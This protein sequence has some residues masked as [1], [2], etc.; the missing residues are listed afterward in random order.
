MAGNK[1]EGNI[2]LFP[3]F[4]RSTCLRALNCPFSIT[5]GG[6]KRVRDGGKIRGNGAREREGTHKS[7]SDYLNYSW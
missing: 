1:L 5:T 4:S 3:Y 2:L 6:L 7:E